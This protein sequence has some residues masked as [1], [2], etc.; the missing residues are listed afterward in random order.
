MQAMF[1]AISAQKLP[2]LGAE[3]LRV[4]KLWGVAG[5]LEVEE[6]AAEGRDGFFLLFP[7]KL[8]LEVAVPHVG[9]GLLRL[10]LLGR[11]LHHRQLLPACTAHTD[12]CIS[13][14]GCL[15]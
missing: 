13:M 8:L 12:L 10:R 14:G 2:R 11:L 4:P 9:V 3:H 5:C 1:R 6:L 7:F 15:G